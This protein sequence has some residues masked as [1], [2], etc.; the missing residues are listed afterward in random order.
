MKITTDGKNW[1]CTNS[2]RWRYLERVLRRNRRLVSDL[3]QYFLYVF[4]PHI[5]IV[6]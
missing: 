4:D 2:K 6:L 3:E 1:S 5:Q